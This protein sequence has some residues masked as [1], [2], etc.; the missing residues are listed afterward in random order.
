[1]KMDLFDEFGLIDC[2]ITPIAVCFRFRY[3]SRMIP[4]RFP[5]RG[6]EQINPTLHPSPTSLLIRRA[7]RRD[8]LI[9][10]TKL[11][12]KG[13]ARIAIHTICAHPTFFRST[14]RLPFGLLDELPISIPYS[15]CAPDALMKF[16]SY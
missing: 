14:Y 13:T 7:N 10:A 3:I 5:Y 4:K 12:H 2:I 15:Y 1:M 6:V 9:L 8:N 11:A 16:W